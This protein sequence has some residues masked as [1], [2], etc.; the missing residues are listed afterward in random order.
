MYAVQC[1]AGFFVPV[2]AG[3]LEVFGFSGMVKDPT[4]PSRVTIIDD[5]TIRPEATLGK[6][7]NSNYTDQFGIID[8]KGVA[9]ETGMVEQIFPEPLKLRYG[10]SAVASNN[11]IAGTLKLYVR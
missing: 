11:M 6:I 8:F 5:K 3:R 10:A 7:Y 1:H 2:K 4:A 9:S